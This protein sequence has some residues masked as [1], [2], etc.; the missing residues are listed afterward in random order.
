MHV[1]YDSI[2]QYIQQH[3]GDL[4]GT[5]VRIVDGDCLGSY[6]SYLDSKDPRHSTLDSMGQHTAILRKEPTM[7]DPAPCRWLRSF[8]VFPW[9][10]RNYFGIGS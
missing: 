9:T 10:K 6:L 1:L 5:S 4:Q 3:L 2:W 7:A 8:T